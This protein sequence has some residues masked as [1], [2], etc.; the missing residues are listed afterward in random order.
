[1]DWA[2]PHAVG[3]SA[4]VAAGA[5]VAGGLARWYRQSR[6]ISEAPP[7]SRPEA[8]G[9]RVM[10]V[11]VIKV[12]GLCC[13]RFEDAIPV[14]ATTFHEPRRG[15]GQKARTVTWSDRATNMWV[16]VAKVNVAIEGPVRVEVG[17]EEHYPGCATKELEAR[18]L[19]RIFSAEIVPSRDDVV[20]LHGVFRS[21][22]PD[23]QVA[24][25]G[26]MERGSKG[27]RRLGRR[28]TEVWRLTP[29]ASGA[30]TICYR[31]RPTV[32][33]ALFGVHAWAAAMVAGVG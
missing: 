21:V 1:M 29:D 13:S 6:A 28:R 2:S 23:D 33:G 11:G 20:P 22:K 10:V 26:R 16:E 27:P 17:S 8:P 15:G 12:E 31:R 32:R 30:I 14:A 9:P 19:E 3:V 7:S 18:V 25:V 4:V 24:V 5:L